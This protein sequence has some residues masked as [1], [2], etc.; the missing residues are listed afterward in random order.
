MVGQ[1]TIA[2]NVA[3]EKRRRR[4]CRH[5]LR[6]K[7]AIKKAAQK[8]E[9]VKEEEQEGEDAGGPE[10]EP[11][12]EGVPCPVCLV[13]MAEPV[14]TLPCKHAFHIHC[15]DLW[16]TTCKAREEKVTCPYCT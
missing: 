5:R 10:D 4:N 3:Q 13:A 12:V 15:M 14:M 1:A 16:D 2:A 7:R 9:E 11:S 8:A 6:K